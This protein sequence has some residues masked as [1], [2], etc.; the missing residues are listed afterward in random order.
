M[1][2][3][4]VVYCPGLDGAVG[5]SSW[6]Q[7]VI[8]VVIVRGSRGETKALLLL[9]LLSE[10]RRDDHRHQQQGGGNNAKGGS[11]LLFVW[12]SGNKNWLGLMHCTRRGGCY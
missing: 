6:I 10:G 11:D 3:H 12:C 1:K 7:G 5:R 8:V 4:C 2:I 9:S